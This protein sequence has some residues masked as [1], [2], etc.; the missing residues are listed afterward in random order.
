MINGKIE[1]ADADILMSIYNKV[2]VDGTL[3][4]GEKFTTD[5]MVILFCVAKAIRKM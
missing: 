5:E 4:P 2:A 1:K 3:K